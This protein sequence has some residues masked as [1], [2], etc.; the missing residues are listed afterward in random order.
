M[1]VN[2]LDDDETYVNAF[3]ITGMQGNRLFPTPINHVTE[4]LCETNTS[5]YL[6]SGSLIDRRVVLCPSH[7]ERSRWVETLRQEAKLVN[8]HVSSKP[9]S[10]QMLVSHLQ[11]SVKS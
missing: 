8:N 6:I 2:P 11:V 1:T 7:T 5:L 4:K 9:Q 3:E 10:L